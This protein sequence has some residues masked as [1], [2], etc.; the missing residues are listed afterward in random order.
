MPRSKNVCQDQLG[1]AEAVQHPSRSQR[2]VLVLAD[3]QQRPLGEGVPAVSQESLLAFSRKSF[4][5]LVDGQGRSVA[6]ESNCI[7]IDRPLDRYGG[8]VHVTVLVCSQSR[9][10]SF[11]NSYSD[12]VVAAR[13][14]ASGVSPIKSCG[15]LA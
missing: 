12:T 14:A 3:Q 9:R 13:N 15:Y 7:R 6:H 5:V 1:T 8:E 10:P 11:M 4:A 2:D